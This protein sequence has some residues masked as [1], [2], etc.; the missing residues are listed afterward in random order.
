MGK[1]TQSTA[2]VQRIL[3]DSDGLE[4]RINATLST[5]VDKEDGK[6]LSTNDF[7]DSEKEKLSQLDLSKIK[8]T[9]SEL[10]T[11]SENPLMNKV[12]TEE[13]DTKQD[14]EE[15]KGLSTE[16]YTT[17]EKKKVSIL[18]SSI[19]KITASGIENE[20]SVYKK[21]IISEGRAPYDPYSGYNYTASSGIL[22]DCYDASA[23][24]ADG[25]L[26]LG[27]SDGDLGK[28]EVEVG[29]WDGQRKELR[30]Y[31]LEDHLHTIAT[32]AEIDALFDG[33]I[34]GDST[35]SM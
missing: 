16:D 29:V 8:E 10:S 31:H 2:E 9:D 32:Q 5:K 14:K 25:F 6:G 35:T 12:V 18:N 13:L 7:T 1:L 4:A 3:N 33:A 24:G 30:A 27:L 11:T 19:L 28:K 26:F 15:G 23:N 21:S 34:S 22:I 20:G 17:I